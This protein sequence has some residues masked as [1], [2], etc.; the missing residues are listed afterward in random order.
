MYAVGMRQTLCVLFLLVVAPVAFA[1]DVT[2]PS[3]VEFGLSI[4]HEGISS[5]EVDLVDAG[6]AVLAT[7]DLGKP[8]GVAGDVVQVAILVQPI[9][10]GHYTGDFRA[11]PTDP[12]FASDDVPG[13]N[14]FDRKPG[15]PSR[16]SFR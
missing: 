11:V 7:I 15:G 16:P 3:Q 5:Y 1:Q 6:G 13:E 4:D 14:E 8:P 12:T 2:N 9:P 10:F